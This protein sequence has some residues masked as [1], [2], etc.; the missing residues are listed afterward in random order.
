ME[1]VI[2]SD[3]GGYQLKEEIKQK[4]EADGVNY[5]DL[6]THNEESVDFGP[7]AKEVAESVA[8]GEYDRGILICGTGIGMSMMANKVKGVRAALVHDVFSAQAARAHNNSNVLCMGARI[9]GSELAKMITEVW[10][11]TEFDGGRH[12]RR[13]N[14]ISDYQN[15]N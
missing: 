1:I 15:N 10:L 4:L 6:G 12:Q 3:H 9:I 11:K 7:I 8:A 2:G 13:I 14:Y 5:K